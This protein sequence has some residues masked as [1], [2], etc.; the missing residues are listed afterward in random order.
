MNLAEENAELL[1]D[2]TIAAGS[3]SK[4][5][6]FKISKS[7]SCL[8]EVP[9]NA[10]P[11]EK[12]LIVPCPKRIPRFGE[13]FVVHRLLPRVVPHILYVIIYLKS[14]KIVFE[15]LNHSRINRFQRIVIACVNRKLK[16]KKC[17][18]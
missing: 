2:L 11:L 15:I 13:F 4:H 14:F 5:F 9:S 1:N 3:L 8:C 17:L 6:T 18:S 16:K 12:N 7:S 10:G